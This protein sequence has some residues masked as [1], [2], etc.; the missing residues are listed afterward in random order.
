MATVKSAVE[1]HA[2]KLDRKAAIY[3]PSPPALPPTPPSAPWPPGGPPLLPLPPPIMPS[4][5]ARRLFYLYF[6][7]VCGLSFAFLSAYVR[8]SRRGHRRRR[9][10]LDWQRTAQNQRSAIV[11]A[12]NALPTTVAR[13]G[14]GI[15]ATEECA[16]CLGTFDDEHGTEIRRLP[17]QHTFHRSCIDKWLLGALDATDGV[18]SCPLCKDVP[19]AH[20]VSSTAAGAGVNDPPIQS[21][22]SPAV[23]PGPMPVSVLASLLQRVWCPG[24]ARL[25]R[26]VAPAPPTVAAAPAASLADA[27]DATHG[28]SAY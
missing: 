16:V 14:D 26:A 8:N 18:P 25:A 15:D 20:L 24:S 27:V 11:A 7:A 23:L 2:S 28:S 4:P 21:Q 10:A 22:Q 17:C 3:P 1:E 13:G 12:L 5:V 9:R 6:L 19:F